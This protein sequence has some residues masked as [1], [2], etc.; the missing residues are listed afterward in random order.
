[1]LLFVYG[2][3]RKREENHELL[4]GAPCVCEQAA[5]NGVLYETDKGQP[6]ASLAETAFVYGE[7]Y[8]TDHQMIRKLDM[9][10]ADFDRKEVAVTT[11]AG[12]KTAFAYVVK[13]GQCAS[14]SRIKSG[15]WKEYRFM[16]REDD[17]PVYYFAYGSCMDNA[18]FKQAGVDHFFAEPVG[19]AVVEGYSTRFTLRRPDG[20]RA[21]LVEDGGR[22]KGV[23]YKLPFEAATYLYKREGVDNHTYRPAF[24]EVCAGGRVYRG[25]LTFLVLDKAEEIAPPGHYQEEIERGADLYLSPA[26]SEKLKRYMN[27]LPK[28]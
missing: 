3:L 23:L 10:Y 12:N 15:D 6:A 11:D 14:F 21:D 26:F 22:T 13:P 2:L 9:Y 16:K 20:S 17:S 19:G 27:S 5:I 1:M 25:V 4:K 28:M 24:I 7:L 8:E 18:R